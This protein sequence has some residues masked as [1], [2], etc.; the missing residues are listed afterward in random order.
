M[1]VCEE[2]WKWYLFINAVIPH[3]IAVYPP[4]VHGLKI[5]SG[6]WL[7]T[8]LMQP[9]AWAW[10]YTSLPPPWHPRCVTDICL[11]TARMRRSASA[12]FSPSQLNSQVL[13]NASASLIW[14][15]VPPFMPQYSYILPSYVFGATTQP[16]RKVGGVHWAVLALGWFLAL[17]QSCSAIRAWSQ[18]GLLYQG[19]YRAQTQKK[20]VGILFFKVSFFKKKWKKRPNE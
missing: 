20:K 18:L 12:R 17:V 6:K 10:G 15:D 13:D 9:W 4:T 11:M 2:V 5:T 14:A 1:F 8:S 19:L 16:Q 7:P 3:V